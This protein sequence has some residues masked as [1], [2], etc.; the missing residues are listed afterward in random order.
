MKKVFITGGAGFIGSHLVKELLVSGYKVTVLDNLSTG[1]LKNLD[2]IIDN[3]NLNFITGDVMDSSL[4]DKLVKDS[5]LVFHLAAV[6]GVKHVMNNPVDTIRVNILGTE[7]ILHSCSSYSRK[8]LIASTSEVY[9]K[10]MQ[11]GNFD[12][13]LNEDN[14][15]VMGSTSVRRWSYATSKALDEFLALAYYAEKKLPVIIARYFNTIGPGQLGDYGMVVPIFIQKAL[16]GE[17][18]P[19][20]GDGNQKRSF[21]YVG[22]AV[23]CTIKLVEQENSLGEVFNIGN[24]NEIT[25]NE[26]ATKIIHKTKS[27]SKLRYIS[28]DKAYGEGFEDM[29]RRKPN[30]AKLERAIGFKP[31]VGIDQIIDEMIIFFK[32]N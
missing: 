27:I 24:N 16:S 3:K 4:V 32:S 1:I 15:T 9:G 14:D 20:F 26:L 30:T 31:E 5:D 6:V 17:D 19:I 7:N 25:I 18:I 13:G 23:K 21:G 10:A 12:D 22:D 28:Y 11:Y 8:V 29:K 2:S